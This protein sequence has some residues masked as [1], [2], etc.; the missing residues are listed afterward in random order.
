MNM[1]RP[2]TIETPRITDQRRRVRKIPPG[3]P[4]STGHVIAI[5]PPDRQWRTLHR[6]VP[7]IA[8]ARLERRRDV[9]HGFLVLA[10]IG[11]VLAALIA[12]LAL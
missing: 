2:A 6:P 1:Q 3:E 8:P 9:G 7:R 4:A 10:G 5:Q 12:G 11:L